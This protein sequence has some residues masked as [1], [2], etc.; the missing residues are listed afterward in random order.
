VLPMLANA[1]RRRAGP[2]DDAL[3]EERF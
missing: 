2:T 1:A 3:I